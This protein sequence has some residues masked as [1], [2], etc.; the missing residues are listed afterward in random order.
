MKRLFFTV[1]N[2][3]TFDQRMIRICTSLSS[4]G[5]RVTL[6]GRRLPG[7]KPSDKMIFHQKRIY[8]LTKK[9]KAFY[10]EYNMR[11]FFYLLFKKMDLICAV[12]LDTILPCY[13]ISKIRRVKRVYD[14][15]EL[16][17]EMKEVISRPAIYHIWKRIE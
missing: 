3:L 7:S 14:A 8:C 1:T 4:A 2:D 13:F 9:G 12:D 10:I 17:C 6:I 5:Y 15:H 11:L 16:F